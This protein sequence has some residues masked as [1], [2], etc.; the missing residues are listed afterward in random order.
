MA[1]KELEKKLEHVQ[2]CPVCKAKAGE[3]D[4]DDWYFCGE[5]NSGILGVARIESYEC[6]ECGC[7]FSVEYKG[8]ISYD[9]TRW[10]DDNDG[11]CDIEKNVSKDTG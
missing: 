11:K 6:P 8:T 1:Y 9:V 3:Y 10:M 7:H 5:L 2:T 4:E